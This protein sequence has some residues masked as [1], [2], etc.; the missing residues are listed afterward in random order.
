MEMKNAI[1]DMVAY[2]FYLAI[3]MIICYGSRDNNS[4][5]QKTAIERALIYGG[6]NCE[7]L[8]SDDPKY[9]ACSKEVLPVKAVMF[10]KVRT[11]ND[12]WTW[13]DKTLL[14]NVRVQPWYNNNP[15]YRYIC[16]YV[17]LAS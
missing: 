6:M 16:S 11:T 7:I 3:I 8:P 13:F 5:R 15:P 12:W 10:S 2:F 17:F 1:K 9:K 4:F 14:P